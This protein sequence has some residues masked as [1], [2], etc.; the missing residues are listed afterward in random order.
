MHTSKNDIIRLY[1]DSTNT[2]H[3]TGVV[4]KD[5]TLLQ[6]KPVGDKNHKRIFT[7]KQEWMN[8]IP[9][10]KSHTI[11]CDGSEYNETHCNLLKKYGILD[12][13]DIIHEKHCDVGYTI[14]EL[15]SAIKT[16]TANLTERINTV[17][18]LENLMIALKVQRKTAEAA[19]AELD[20]AIETYQ[21]VFTEHSD[22]M[23]K[24]QERLSR[25]ELHLTKLTK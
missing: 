2:F 17:S 23:W 14:D 25:Y 5:G 20:K 3:Y 6:I 15:K 18:N 13:L 21:A 12:E 22:D 7:N 9:H 1:P 8:E 19:I 4:L 11:F 16:T 24:T 10:E